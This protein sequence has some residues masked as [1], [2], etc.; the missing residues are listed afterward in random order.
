[1]LGLNLGITTFFIE[2]FENVIKFEITICYFYQTLSIYL[3][4]ERER[5]R[6][7]EGESLRKDEERERDSLRKER[8]R[9]SLSLTIDA[10]LRGGGFNLL[11][12]IELRIFVAD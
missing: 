8:Q 11:I 5:D 9:L 3:V 7:R 12:R 10:K 2:L 1:M 4:R 6:E